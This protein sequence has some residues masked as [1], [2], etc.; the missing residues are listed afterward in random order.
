M[1]VNPGDTF[2]FEISESEEG[3]R[4]DFVISERISSVSRTHVSDLIKSGMIKIDGK[5][6]KPGYHV[7]EGEM[8]T[9]FLPFP[10]EYSCGPEDIQIDI[11]FE[12]KDLV[13]INKPPGLVVHPAPGHETGTLVNALIARCPD[14]QGI[15]G[16]LR[17]GIVHRLDKDTSGL[18]IAAKNHLSHMALIEM[19]KTR[20]IKK[21]YLS[22]IVGT[23]SR[24]SG[25]ID[26]PI[27]RHPV[28]RKKMSVLSRSGR[29]AVTLWRLVE[30]LGCA[31][32]VEAEI[33]TG[34]THQIRVHFESLGHPV[35]GDTVYGVK[36][37]LALKKIVGSTLFPARQ[38]L[39]SWSLGFKHPVSGQDLE[40]LAELPSD[41]MSFIDH[42]RLIEK[43]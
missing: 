32:L 40:F 36:K 9:G 23:P 24:D 28:E 4:L 37:N 29:D 17:P 16:E 38:M 42:V 8:V 7:R 22:L 6:K 10:R 1:L 30:G 21:K 13:V 5:D 20:E 33:K 27:G 14:L 39:H 34:R 43:N 15:G 18:M 41:M 19:F 26:L 12:D 2:K 3:E 11:V 31:S 35:V 25:I